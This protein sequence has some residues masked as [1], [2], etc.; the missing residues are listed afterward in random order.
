MVTRNFTIEEEP[1]IV[2]EA[3]VIPVSCRGA[4]DA[5]I[6]IS[7]TEDST[8]RFD[9][10][11]SFTYTLSSTDG[12][13]TASFTRTDLNDPAV[14]EGLEAGLEYTWT[15]INN[16]TIGCLDTSIDPILLED[17]TDIIVDNGIFDNINIIQTGGLCNCLLYTSPSPRDQR[18]ARMPSSA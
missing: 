13:F 18:G 2:A 7:I 11:L 14:F 16:N 5:Q 1:E 3:E 9:R 15:V 12:S 8:N 17:K 6:S 4:D 10:P